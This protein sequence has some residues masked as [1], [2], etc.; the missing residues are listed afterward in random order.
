MEIKQNT[1]NNHWIKEEI[2]KEMKIVPKQ[3]RM[4]TQHI[5]YGM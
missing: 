2:K 3:I 1:L 5:K 4:K